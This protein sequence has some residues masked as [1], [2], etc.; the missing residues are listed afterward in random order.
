MIWRQLDVSKDDNGKFFA[1]FHLNI[2]DN[3]EE[4]VHAQKIFNLDI[5]VSI[6]SK[7]TMIF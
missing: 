2:D 5:D 6:C 4:I 3:K 1:D 7:S